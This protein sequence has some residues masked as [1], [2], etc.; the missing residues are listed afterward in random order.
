MA[1][2]LADTT[3]QP[4][5]RCEILKSITLQNPELKAQAAGARCYQ[6]P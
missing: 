4:A 3:I 6:A 5:D 2:L 1:D